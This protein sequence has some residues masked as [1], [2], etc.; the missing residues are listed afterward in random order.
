M[1]KRVPLLITAAVAAVLI[2]GAIVYIN[3]RF[4]NNTIGIQYTPDLPE[5]WN[6]NSADDNASGGI[7]IPGFGRLYFPSD[8][9]KVQMTLANPNDNECYFIYSIHLN[10]PDGELLYTSDKV[11]PGMAIYDLTLYRTLEAGE[12]VLYIH[13]APYAV[14][15]GK[16]LNTA[17]LKMP[18]T[19]TEN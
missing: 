3:I 9:D 16:Q 5:A 15:D 2:I 4:D 18:L 11:Y 6:E 19:V 14:S 1:K 10:E 7:K 13:V 17:L 12:Y 8:T